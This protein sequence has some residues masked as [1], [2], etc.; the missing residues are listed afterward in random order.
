MMDLE[1]PQDA[2]TVGTAGPLSLF[3]SLSRIALLLILN[4][5]ILFPSDGYARIS[6]SA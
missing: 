2:W 1:W 5:G 4:M 3:C 6:C